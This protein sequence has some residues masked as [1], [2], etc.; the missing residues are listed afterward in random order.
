MGIE[1]IARELNILRKTVCIH[2][3][4]AIEAGHPVDC[5]ALNVSYGDVVKTATAIKQKFDSK[6]VDSDTISKAWSMDPEKTRLSLSLIKLRYGLTK[7]TP[8]Q[9]SEQRNKFQAAI[10]QRQVANYAQNR[11][12][13]NR[14]TFN[15]PQVLGPKR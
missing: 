5:A 14:P 12:A 2:F 6:I 15:R 7:A 1:S 11:P 9:Q 8:E 3:A 4:R 10:E 13:F